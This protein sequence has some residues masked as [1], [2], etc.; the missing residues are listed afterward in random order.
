[1]RAVRVDQRPIRVL[2]AGRLVRVR[3][4]SVLVAAL[5]CRSES[6]VRGQPQSAE[7]STCHLEQFHQLSTSVHRAVV[8]CT[9]CHGGKSVYEVAPEVVR[10]FDPAA[11]AARSATTAPMVFDHGPTFRGKAA[12]SAIPTVCG[13]CHSDVE[14]MN[15]FGLQTDQLAS[16]WVSGHG[17]RLKTEG[18]VRVAVCIDCHGSHDVKRSTDPES[19]TFFRNIPATCGRCHSDRALMEPYHIPA[20]IPEQYA[21]SIH[22]RNVLEK[23]DSGSPNCATC[24]G[25]HAAAPPGYLEVGHVCGKRHQQIE[26][27]FLT[28]VHGKIPVMAR[29]IG[30]HAK[31]GQRWNHEIEKASPSIE[32][33]LSAYSQARKEAG[34][35][36]GELR[37]RFGELVDKECGSVN[38]GTVCANCHTPGRKEAHSQFFVTS[39]ERARECG[40]EL[41]TAVRD[42]QFAY[43]RTAERVTRLAR[44]VLLVRNEAG[45]VEDAKTEV[46]ALNA[47]VHTLDRAETQVRVKK[48]TE[49]CDQVNAELDEKENGL[50]LRR[51]A[52]LPVWA[53]IAVFAVLMYSKFMALKRK[54]VTAGA[55]ACGETRMVS[56]GRRGFLNFIL[57]PMG[58]AALL[59][60]LWPAISYV[61]P[62]RRRVGAGE[63]VSAGKEAGWAQWESRKVLVR[64]KPV[65][66]IRTDNG[67]R[68]YSAICTHLGCIVHWNGS[69]RHFV[70]PCHAA[71]FDATGKVVSGPPPKP[72]P[73]YSVS[74]VQG[75]VMV[76]DV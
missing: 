22:G 76:K 41:A 72:L 43:A 32:L 20:T 39:D 27:Y 52:L 13:T 36:P 62:A 74:V 65:A 54:Y 31:G 55:G 49:I 51:L 4:V 3:A 12:R 9:E 19:R 71:T 59:A 61:L 11:R 30:C 67:F 69:D 33:V 7:C 10:Q 26:E 57:G 64:G 24:H 28:S 58:A 35:S 23:G 5:I 29:C 56:W 63:R 70:C 16:Y 48:T 66:V 50:V 53:F 8:R 45:Q 18:D 73:E 34:E 46:L 60:I 47:F 75:E 14:K 2:S 1:M 38:L 44:G 68:A 17:K 40:Q 21:R 25:S 37:Q 15:P 42:A 6:S